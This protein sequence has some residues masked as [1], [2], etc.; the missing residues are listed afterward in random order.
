MRMSNDVML[1]ALSATQVWQ[2]AN[3]MRYVFLPGGHEQLE[4]DCHGTQYPVSTG[5]VRQV[6]W[7]RHRPGFIYVVALAVFALSTVVLCVLPATS[8]CLRVHASQV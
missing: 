7:W 8:V 1:R 3:E 6:C 2:A 5:S 4:R